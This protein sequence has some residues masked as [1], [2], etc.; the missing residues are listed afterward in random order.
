MHSILHS[1]LPSR[2]LSHSTP[3]PV[4]SVLL[5]AIS[6]GGDAGQRTGGCIQRFEGVVMEEIVGRGFRS[7]DSGRNGSGV[8]RVMGVY[9]R[10]KSTRRHPRGKPVTAELEEAA[11]GPVARRDEQDEQQDR[12]VD[13]WPVEKVRAHE[14]QEYEGRRGIRG[15]EE[16]RDP[17]K[18][19]NS[20]QH[21][22]AYAI[23]SKEG[24]IMGGGNRGLPP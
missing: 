7:G 5:R 19:A 17:A 2:P 18:V 11:V 8:C 12:T 13:A 20:G 3:S 9:P 15:D 14:E 24:R 16:E 23:R 4:H 10:L 1:L 22:D 6:S 21:D